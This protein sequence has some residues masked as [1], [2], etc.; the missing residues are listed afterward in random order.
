MR[1]VDTAKS[2]PEPAYQ[3]LMIVAVAAAAG[4]VVDRFVGLGWWIWIGLAVVGLAAWHPLWRRERH[5]PAMIALGLSV[6]AVS[7]AWHHAQWRLLAP[8]DLGMFARA[9]SE[10]VCL[11]AVVASAPHYM[12]APP[13]NRMA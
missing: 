3:P 2:P 12:T 7:G 13:Y 9:D 6:A 10:P 8:D 11:Q 1:P 4:I 5:A